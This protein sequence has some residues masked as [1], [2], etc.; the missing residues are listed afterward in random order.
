MTKKDFKTEV[1]PATMFINTVAGTPAQMQ[2][3]KKNETN[4][5]RGKGVTPKKNPKPETLNKK[6][7]KSKRLNLL[8]QPSLLE[9]LSKIA[10]MNKDSVNNLINSA[11]LEYRDANKQ[12]IERYNKVFEG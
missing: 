2:A 7:T 1:N 10:T 11:L 8:L 9:D 5:S 12:T 6:E 3:P 4:K